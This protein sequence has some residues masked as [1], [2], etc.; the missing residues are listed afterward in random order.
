ML[1]FKPAL[2]KIDNR[3]ALLTPEDKNLVEMARKVN[4]NIPAPCLKNQRK[5]GCCRACLVEING[6]SAYACSTKPTAGM[7]VTVRRKDL[8]EVRKKAI[9]DFKLQV[10]PAVNPACYCG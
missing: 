5:R 6:Q 10:K 8:D 1:V 2:I 4:I 7:V 3:E 9:K